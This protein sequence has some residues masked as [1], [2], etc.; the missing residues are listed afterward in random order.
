MNSSLSI[1]LICPVTSS[2]SGTEVV[3]AA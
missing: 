2:T 1:K 3:E